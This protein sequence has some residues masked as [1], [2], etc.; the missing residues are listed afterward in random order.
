MV[1]AG[2]SGL[3]IASQAMVTPDQLVSRKTGERR[4]SLRVRPQSPIN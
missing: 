4:E 1:G 3:A 2:P